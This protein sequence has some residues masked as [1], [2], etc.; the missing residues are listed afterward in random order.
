MP[1]L[2]DETVE[3]HRRVVR[4]TVEDA[5][6]SLVTEHGLRAVTMAKVA[7]AAGLSRATIYKYFA[8]VESILAAWHQRHVDVHVAQLTALSEVAD[9]PGR[10]L[11][12]ILAAYAEIVAQRG[13]H[14]P[15]LGGLLHRAGEHRNSEELVDELLRRVLTS[16]VDS[17]QV[18]ADIGVNR[19]VSYCRHALGGAAEF[20]STEGVDCLVELTLAGLRPDS[21]RQESC[22]A[23]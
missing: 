5:A 12:S 10:V 13:Q 6:W 14:G 7:A 4:E 2:W 9:E 16:A 15:E 18:R 19:L 23:R 17:G 8:D 22:E 21:A 20:L 11:R 1:K 3:S